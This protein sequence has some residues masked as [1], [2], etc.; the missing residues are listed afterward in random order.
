MSMKRFCFSAMFLLLWISALCQVPVQVD[1][2]MFVGFLRDDGVFVIYDAKGLV[3]VKD[4]KF[5]ERLETTELKL[6]KFLAVTDFYNTLDEARAKLGLP[7]ITEPP[8]V[9]VPKIETNYNQDYSWGT[10]QVGNH[11]GSKYDVYLQ[12]IRQGVSIFRFTGQNVF[13]PRYDSKLQSTEELSIIALPTH[14]IINFAGTDFVSAIE[15]KLT[16]ESGN[17]VWYLYDTRGG[18]HPCIT[19]NGCDSKL[20]GNNHPDDATRWIKNGNYKLWVKNLSTDARAVQKIEFGLTTGVNYF[21]ND[22]LP[23][24]EQ[25]FDLNISRLAAGEYK[26]NCNVFTPR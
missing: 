2:G 20:R 7:S 9:D 18:Y 16:D 3:T 12:E 1:K 13:Y 15:M 14:S 22:L 5:A 6:S 25:T 4:G 19:G 10:G 8:K 17:E 26:I 21:S 11:Y 24:H 23:G